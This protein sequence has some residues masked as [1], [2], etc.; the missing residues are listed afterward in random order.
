MFGHLIL[1]FFCTSCIQLLYMYTHM[2]LAICMHMYAHYVYVHCMYIH[3]YAR[4]VHVCGH[5]TTT[6]FTAN[7]YINT[8]HVYTCTCSLASQTLSGGLASETNVRVHT[9]SI[10]LQWCDDG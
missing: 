5:Q 9:S 4:C 3:V 8:L 6:R 1:L 2:Q 10:Q 7:S